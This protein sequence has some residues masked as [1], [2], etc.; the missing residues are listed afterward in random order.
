MDWL[1]VGVVVGGA[2]IVFIL[3]VLC[4]AKILQ[5]CS[6][7]ADFGAHAE[8]SLTT[9][10]N[11]IP[12]IFYTA[13]MKDPLLWADLAEDDKDKPWENLPDQHNE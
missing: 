1:I 7:A 5:M 9:T 13:E 8:D 11:L 3:L 4:C 2:I 12:P 10:E 6:D